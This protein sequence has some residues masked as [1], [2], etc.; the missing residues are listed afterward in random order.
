MTI[1][2]VKFQSQL[3][4]NLEGVRE[5][6]ISSPYQPKEVKVIIT[7]QKGKEIENKVKML[8]KKTTKVKPLD[9]NDSSPKEKKDNNPQKYIY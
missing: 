4:P 6:S 8:V 9:S 2:K 7:F 5:V 3:V 1:E